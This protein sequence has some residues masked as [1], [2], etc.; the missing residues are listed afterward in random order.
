MIDQSI[1][2]RIPILVQIR[3][4]AVV[5][6]Y[7]KKEI[8]PSDEDMSDETAGDAYKPC[9]H[10]VLDYYWGCSDIENEDIKSWWNANENRREELEEECESPETIFRTCPFIDHLIEYTSGGGLEAKITI[11]F[12]FRTH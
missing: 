4:E 6:P 2:P 11:T 5:C 7:C 3:E 8:L 12:G 1:S 9:E 10:V